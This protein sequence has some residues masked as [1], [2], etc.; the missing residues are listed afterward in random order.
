[1]LRVELLDIIQ[2]YDA[3][4]HLVVVAIFSCAVIAVADTI[5]AIQLT[6]VL[7]ALSRMYAPPV[8]L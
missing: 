7:H 5:A 3:V 2:V 6:D 8:A 4:A 1:M